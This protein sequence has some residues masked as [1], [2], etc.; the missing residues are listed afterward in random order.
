M[1]S[2]TCGTGRIDDDVDESASLDNLDFDDVESV[3][4]EVL[5]ITGEAEQR[6]GSSQNQSIDSQDE[7]RPF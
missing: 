5:A 6:P 1:F 7:V 3:N 4:S 2:A